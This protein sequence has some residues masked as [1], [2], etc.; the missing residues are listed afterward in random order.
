MLGRV[1]FG[2]FILCALSCATTQHGSADIGGG[3][4]VEL[5]SKHFDVLTDES[6][7][8]AQEI[9]HYLE[10]T[11]AAMLAAVWPRAKVESSHPVD[12][13]VLDSGLTYEKLFSRN[14][15]GLFVGSRDSG[16]IALY[17]NPDHWE[18][19]RTLNAEGSTSVLK[20]EMVHR[21]ASLVGITQPRWL[22][23]GLAQFLETLKVASDGKS[24]EIGLVNMDALSAY[25]H[26]RTVGV[27]DALDWHG[28]IDQYGQA[29]TAARYGMSWAMVHWLYNTH[30]AQF[31]RY[32]LALAQGK[33]SKAAWK[34]AFPQLPPSKADEAIHH[35]LKT[36]NYQVF[37]VKL[38]AFHEGAL[39]VRPLSVAETHALAARLEVVA[40]AV[41][42]NH[43]AAH[44]AIARKEIAAAL[45]AD[46]NDINALRMAFAVATGAK[47]ESLARRAVKAH[48][49]VGAA[50]MMLGEALAGNDT[51]EQE[52]ALLRAA[53]LS[54]RNPKPLNELAWARVTHGKAAAALPYA[55]KA[56][57]L[58]PANPAVLDTYAATLAGVGRCQDAVTTE[59]RAMGLLSEH[60]SPKTVKAYA[61]RLKKLETGCGSKAAAEKPSASPAK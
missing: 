19:R 43:R 27:E 7:D 45:V 30:P 35:Y 8:D 2:V 25:T 55:L 4:W 16:F 46:P 17:G 14:I 33:R 1:V 3:R 12:V 44:L 11:R 47:R 48:P 58:A 23:E 39:V 5:R 50:W 59:T 34:V 22:A 60:A 9:A 32:Q 52:S 26:L 49:D 51:A 57:M 20:H 37:T 18:Q 6:L 61:S 13:V 15:A 53:K 29:S 54:P 38:P 42:S 24:A 56:K 10:R 28:P 40:A 41:S 36:G 31:A 21:L